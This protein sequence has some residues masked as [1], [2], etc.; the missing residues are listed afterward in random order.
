MQRADGRGGERER[1]K[2][3]CFFTK[4]INLC[5]LPYDGEVNEKKIDNYIIYYIYIPIFSI[6]EESDVSEYFWSRLVG[7]SPEK[8]RICVYNNV[9]RSSE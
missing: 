3:I 4:M 7:R 9:L 8:L 1:E 6:I 5:F 2:I